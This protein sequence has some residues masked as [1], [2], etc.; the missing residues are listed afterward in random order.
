[1]KLALSSLR[2]ALAPKQSSQ[3]N[4]YKKQLEGFYLV[5]PPKVGVFEEK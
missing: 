4:P 5:R 2:G 3:T 1:L